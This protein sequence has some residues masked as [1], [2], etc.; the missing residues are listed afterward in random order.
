MSKQ[1]KK[2]K[3]EKKTRMATQ[4]IEASDESFLLQHDEEKNMEDEES[5][6]LLSKSFK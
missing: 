2:K 6:F 1:T 5:T 4:S 3:K